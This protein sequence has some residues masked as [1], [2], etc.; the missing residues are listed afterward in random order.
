MSEVRPPPMFLADSPALDFLNSVAVPTDTQV[1]WL[2][3]GEDLLNWLREAG[4]VDPQVLREP[5]VRLRASRQA[6]R[7]NELLGPVRRP[8]H[9]RP[10]YDILFENRS[11]SS[12][13]HTNLHSAVI[14][15][16]YQS[17]ST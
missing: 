8:S 4:M 11:R 10:V 2:G 13:Q 7:P 17:V 1:E 12:E 5:A 6:C 9:P 16:P 3:S 15:G 14:F